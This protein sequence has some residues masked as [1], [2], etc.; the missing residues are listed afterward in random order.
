MYACVCSV[1]S[2]FFV[3]PWTVARQAPLSI[4]FLR[5]ENLSGLPFPSPGDLL[6]PGI[7]PTSPEFTGGFFTTVL[8]RSSNNHIG[9]H[10]FSRAKGTKGGVGVT[11]AQEG[12][13]LLV[14]ARILEEEAIL[15]SH[16]QRLQKWWCQ[17]FEGVRRW[18]Q[19]KFSLPSAL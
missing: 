3:I 9:N 6:N 8:P 17:G 13:W 15:W 10:Y 18:A 16:C 14:G 7:E 1:V 12:P 2:Q 5:Q 11:A 4:E 19:P